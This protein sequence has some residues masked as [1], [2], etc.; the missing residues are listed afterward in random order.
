MQDRWLVSMFGSLAIAVGVGQFPPAARPN[1]T[2]AAIA[3][4]SLSALQT[5]TDRVTFDRLQTH[6]PSKA[7]LPWGSC[8]AIPATDAARNALH[9]LHT[10]TN[11]DTVGEGSY[12]QFV[13]YSLF[14]VRIEAREERLD[15]GGLFRVFAEPV[16]GGR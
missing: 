12:V 8:T 1:A 14:R 13:W 16:F 15:V 7:T 2:A 4:A 5:P 6:T 3:A 10:T 11:G 9:N